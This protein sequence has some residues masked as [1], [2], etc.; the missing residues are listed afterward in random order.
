MAKDKTYKFKDGVVI[1]GAYGRGNAGDEAILK[2]MIA[3]L[4][5]L[6]A[7]MPIVVMSR[8]PAELKKR[9]DVDSIFTFNPFAFLKAVK[10]AKLFISGGGSLVQDV[11]SSRSFYFYLLTI[12]MAKRR[13]CKCMMYGCGVGPIQKDSHKKFAAKIINKNVDVI[14]L[15]DTTTRQLLKEIGVDK[16]EIV[17][18]ADP[19]FSL[20]KLSAS[21]IDAA[22]KK[23]GIPQDQRLIAFCLRPWK[24][25]YN[26]QAIADAAKYAYRKA[27]LV[28]V[29]LP[30]EVPADIQ[31]GKDIARLIPDVPCVVC[32]GSHRDAEFI[33]ML[34]R[35]ELVVG[36]RL[37]SLLFATEAK[38]PTIAL[39]YD[40]K[41]DGFYKDLEGRHLLWVENITSED[42]ILAI[43]SA[44]NETDLEL[45]YR[46]DRFIEAEKN[47]AKLAREYLFGTK[48]NVVKI[49]DFPIMNLTMESAIN[50]FSA[51]L[52]KDKMS[53]VVTANPEILNMA[54]KNVELAHVVRNADMVFADGIALLTISKFFK[55]PFEERIAGIDFAYNACKECAKKG[56][57]VFLLG[58]KEGVAE[59]AAENLMAEIPGLNIVG[60]HN[61]YFSETEDLEIVEEINN[62][63][64]EF[65]CVAMG[66]PRQELF[67]AH[68]QDK[69]KV[70]VGVGIGGSLDVWSGNVNRAPEFYLKHGIEWLY[71]LISEPKRFGRIIKIPFFMIKAIFKH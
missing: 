36:M 52:E 70:R 49:L 48:A 39:S 51:M 2:A 22:F 59:K 30:V 68:N 19:S 71:R 62:S 1:C 27:G 66:A 3:E 65:L 5:A 8:K 32:T 35:M 20:E 23:E 53:I 25:F 55:T 11:T 63:G 42:L 67:M 31:I 46:V 41:I 16:P 47:N 33:G 37:H 13:G 9:F 10:A 60:T 54:S 45:S 56:T 26:Y 69:L 21:S 28:P 40:V 18:A 44:L 38:V 57:K 4:K 43:E 29:F 64:A 34:S 7:N 12:A 58:G 14:T 50:R 17:Q 61:G 24:D 15:R 6:D